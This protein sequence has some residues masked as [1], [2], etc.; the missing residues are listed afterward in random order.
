MI[1]IID[2]PPIK[3]ERIVKEVVDDVLGNLEFV[4]EDE[5]TPQEDSHVA[6]SRRRKE[7]YEG[8]YFVRKDY[9]EKLDSNYNDEVEKEPHLADEDDKYKYSRHFFEI[10]LVVNHGGRNLLKTGETGIGRNGE[11]FWYFED[12]E[13]LRKLLAEKIVPLLQTVVMKDF[14]EQLEDELEYLAKYP[15]AKQHINN[16]TQTN[17][18]V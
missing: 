17:D 10:K 5:I 6:Y 12:E 4:F 1:K 18:G 13:D 16:L 9:S 8:I 15:E 14:D 11:E 3:F 7:I 2:A